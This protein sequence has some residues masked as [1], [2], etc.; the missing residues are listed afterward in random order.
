MASASLPITP[1]GGEL[2]RLG[3]DLHNST[4]QS[5][6]ALTANLDVVTANTQTL[7]GRARKVLEDSAVI[8]RECFHQLLALA[9]LLCPPSLDE[10]TPFVAES[11]ASKS[12]GHVDRKRLYGIRRRTAG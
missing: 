2:R 3:F 8:A 1:R 9:D 5:L 12:S 10:M 7:D 6:A 4:V 11:S